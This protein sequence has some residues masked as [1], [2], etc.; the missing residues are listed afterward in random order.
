MR[1]NSRLVPNIFALFALLIPLLGSAVFATP[2]YASTLTVDT[3]TDELDGSCNDDCSLRDAIDLANFSGDTI[4]F[5]VT[6]TITLTSQLEIGKDITIAGPGPELL[7]IS[8]GDASR[9]FFINNS[10]V[11][12]TISGLTISH[13]KVTDDDGGGIRNH[14]TLTLD[15]VVV[16]NNSAVTSS[17]LFVDGGGI[18]NTNILVITNSQI[19]NNEGNFTGGG[20]YD[21]GTSL[22]LSNVTISGNNAVGS[23]G[24]G[25]GGGIASIASDSVTMDSVSI[26]SNT[27]KTGAAMYINNVS[28]FEMYNSLVSSNFAEDHIGGVWLSSTSGIYDVRNSTISGNQQTVSASGLG[29]GVWVDGSL[30]ANLFHVTITQNIVEGTGGGAGILTTGTPIVNVKN[31]IIAGNTSS[32]STDEDCNGTINSQNYNLIQDADGNC[33][34]N[35]VTTNNIISQAPLLN[36]LADNGGLTQ[37]HSLQAGSPA[38]DVIPNTIAGCGTTFTTDQRGISRPQDGNGDLTADCDMGALELEITPPVVSSVT[39]VEANPTAAASVDYTVTF[40]EPV[41]GVNTSAPFDDFVVTTTGVIGAAVTAVSGSG[42]NYTVTVN[43]GTKSGTLRLDVLDDDGI[44]DQVGNGMNGNF[45]SGEIYTVN[46]SLTFKSIGGNDGF[47]LESTETSGN[48]GSANS[49]ATTFNLGDDTADRQYRAILHFDTSSLPDNAIVTSAS[50]KIKKQGLV[51][52][53]PFNILGSLKASM[54]KPAFGTTLLTLSDFKSAAGKNNV[55][56]FGVTPVSNWYSAPLNN[57][58]RLYI[59]RTGTTQFR[60]SFTTDDDNDNGNDFMK[61]YSGN[62]GAANRPQLVIEYYVP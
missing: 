41:T 20:I 5:S 13:G 23:G 32:N 43:T 6:G 40:S 50:L 58:G 44:Q 22:S 47:I 46:K 53:N 60:L 61:F 18:Y 7:T 45:T 12:V 11:T 25:I 19:T 27:A 38:L 37:T 34:I 36:P 9:V 14:G 57:T 29:G 26:T 2:A 8:G 16:D 31:S 56:I 21:D 49:A 52:T 4:S 51:G 15:N 10:A 42:D 39:R 1:L 24:G 3:L 59:N 17:F 28:T 55:A 35:G 30:T 33:T 48:G 62:A 54:R